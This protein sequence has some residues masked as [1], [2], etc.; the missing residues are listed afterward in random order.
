MICTN[1]FVYLFFELLL[2]MCSWWFNAMPTYL[3]NTWR[4]RYRYPDRWP[5]LK[6]IYIYIYMCVCV[7]V[8]II[9]AYMYVSTSYGYVTSSLS[10][11]PLFV[12][13]GPDAALS[14]ID[15][16]CCICLSTS[17]KDWDVCRWCRLCWRGQVF[18]EGVGWP[19]WMPTWAKVALMSLQ[20]THTHT[21]SS[22]HKWFYPWQR[23]SAVA[24]RRGWHRQ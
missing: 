23:S 8:M 10:D 17:K 19:C 13:S 24:F 6:H 21:H 5:R 18:P 4:V 3:L 14:W 20:Q 1:I 22:K 9:C 15:W 2:C 7:S 11:D 16:N 12:A